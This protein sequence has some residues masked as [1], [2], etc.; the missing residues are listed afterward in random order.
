MKKTIL[1]TLLASMV[2]TG[3]AVANPEIPNY[4]PS[5][6]NQ[7]GRNVDHNNGDTYVDPENF[8]S[9]SLAEA[10]LRSLE[11]YESDIGEHLGHVIIYGNQLTN[12]NEFIETRMIH[13]NLTLHDN[14]L[15][16]IRGFQ[17]LERIGGGLQLYN[18]RIQ[19][20][21]LDGFLSL[22]FI[23]GDILMGE[24]T[25]KRNETV[26]IRGFRNLETV[27]N[28]FRLSGIK[29]ES[30]SPLSNLSSVGNYFDLSNT[31]IKDVSGLQR[32]RYVSDMNLSGNP[33]MDISGLHRL[34]VEGHILIDKQA[35]NNPNFRGLRPSAKLCQPGMAKHFHPDGATQDDVC[36]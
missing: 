14:P 27:G 10:Q 9:L 25:F 20:E 6:E 16:H 31:G 5:T 33:L 1:S 35:A 36:G 15:Q 4:K 23:G 7:V 3:T 22:K 19:R 26:N 34:E 24:S 8:K 28:D 12:V 13:G 29:I 18:T 17:S 21:S 32:L 11:R 2:I 30:L